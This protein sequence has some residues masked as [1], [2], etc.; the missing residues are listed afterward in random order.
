[1][2]NTTWDTIVIGGSAAGLSAALMLGRARRRVLVIDAGSPR[3]RFAEHMHGVLGH[4]GVSPRALV[5]RGRAEAAEYG[6]EFVTDTVVGVVETEHGLT[7]RSAGAEWVTRAL[8]VATGLTDV[9]ADIPGLA[10]RWG[11]TVLHCPYCHGWEVRDQR[12]GVITTSPLGIHQAELVRQWSERVTVFS[13]GLGDA[14]SEITTRLESRGIRVVDSPV[15]EVLGEGGAMRAIR[16]EDGEEFAVDAVFTAG[17]P[18]PHD[19]FLA[20]LA[21]ERVDG[22]MGSFIQVDAVGKTSASR[23]WAAGNVVN[24]AANV[25]LSMGAGSFAG[26]AVN[27]FL[28]TEDFDRAASAARSPHDFWENR[29]ADAQQIWSGDPNKVIVD[30]VSGMTP[31]RALDLGCGEGGDVIWLAGEGWTVTGLDLSPTAI[32]RATAAAQKA[33][34]ADRVRLTSVDLT[35][36]SSEET[37]DLVTASFF[38]SPVALERTTILQRAARNVAPGGHLL[39]V[40]HAGFP[41]WSQAARHHEHHFLSPQEEVAALDLPADEWTAVIAE[42]RPRSVVSP[43]GEPHTLDDVVVLLRRESS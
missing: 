35:T 40:S 11:K 16:T 26:A 13:A 1:M 36:W 7:V 29:Y 3:N 4:E 39:I 21:L 42:S 43:E 22:P 28:V 23:V 17:T 41:S 19:E 9:L 8:I 37:Y 34:V 27:A 31:G 38:H 24:P 30:V 20:E 18:H 14:T 5:E 10:E 6:V 32:A 15:V 12:L 33:G 2:T 25:P